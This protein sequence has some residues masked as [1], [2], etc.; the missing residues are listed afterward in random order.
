M[1]AASP[2][3]IRHAR[4]LLGVISGIAWFPFGIAYPLVNSGGLTIALYAPAVMIAAMPWGAGPAGIQE[5]MPNKMRGQASAVYL[6]IINLMGLGFGPYILSLFTQYVF[7]SDEGVRWS[8]LAVPVGAHAISATL[9]LLAIRPY[10]KSLDR[11][12][13]WTKA[14]G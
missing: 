7:R 11:L 14:G 6:F 13:E 1:D 5:M 9:L 4:I 8:L 3:G 2:A 10:H 12:E